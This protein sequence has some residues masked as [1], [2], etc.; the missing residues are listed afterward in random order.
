M[1]QEH[2]DNPPP[3]EVATGKQRA[4]IS[5]D[6]KSIKKVQERPD[7]EKQRLVVGSASLREGAPEKVPPEKMFPEKMSPEKMPSEKRKREKNREVAD[8]N[9]AI[10]T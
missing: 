3:Y 9:A 8:L 1:G 10:K 4:S 5:K 7:N 2:R 6:E